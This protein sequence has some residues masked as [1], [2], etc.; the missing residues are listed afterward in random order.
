M[1]EAWDPAAETAV[2]EPAVERW[3]AGTA[4]PLI[5]ALSAGGWCLIALAALALWGWA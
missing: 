2:P 4:L 1:M 3:G 5:L